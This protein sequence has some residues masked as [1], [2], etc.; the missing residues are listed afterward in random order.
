MLFGRH[1]L[2]GERATEL[3]GSVAVAFVESTSGV[4][5]NAPTFDSLRWAGRHSGADGVRAPVTQFLLAA[6]AHTSSYVSLRARG[7]TNYYGHEHDY[8]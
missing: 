7:V 8:G 3:D 1:V 4:V 6:S 2:A 5:C